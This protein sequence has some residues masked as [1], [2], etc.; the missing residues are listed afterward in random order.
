MHI[1]AVKTLREFWE[2]P[3]YHD[4]KQP[5]KAW[6]AEAKHANWKTPADIKAQYGHASII[7]NNR[8]VFNIA[9]NKYR[10]VIKFHYNRG[11]GYVR[12]IGT[13]REYDKIDAEVV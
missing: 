3:D 5:L 11:V 10:L 4:A 12:F 1:I 2:D 7:G 6:Y 13:H 8:V 9:G